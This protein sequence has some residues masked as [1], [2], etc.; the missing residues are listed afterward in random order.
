[1]HNVCRAIHL[2]YVQP[3]M[4]NMNLSIIVLLNFMDT[5]WVRDVLQ[6]YSLW[7]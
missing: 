4:T 2:K 1:M 3:F 7:I 5:W 6:C